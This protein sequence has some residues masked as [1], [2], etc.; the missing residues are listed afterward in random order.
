MA[1][2]PLYHGTD[3][4]ILAMSDGE[5]KKF[6]EL[7]ALS[8]EYLWKLFD[9]YVDRR[10]EE[11][12][13]IL[14]NGQ[15]ESKFYDLYYTLICVDAYRNGRADYQY[16]HIYLTNMISRAIDYA[17]R[18]FAFGEFGFHAYNMLDAAHIIK[19]TDWN[20]SPKEEEALSTL[21]I[22]AESKAEPI[23]LEMDDYDINNL[24]T[25]DG[26]P[27]PPGLLSEYCGMSLRYI[28][29]LPLRNLKRMTAKEAFDKWKES[30]RPF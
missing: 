20:P 6:K 5:R 2:I 9:S 15:D 7:C 12:K 11:L 4:R 10:L 23:V 28:G 30:G 14:T 27:L 3:A 8:I 26:G 16:E 1:N 24:R 21:Q 17:N 25:E 18:S 29:E 22:F 19:F 13:S